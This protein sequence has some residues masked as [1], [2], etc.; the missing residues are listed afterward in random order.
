[1]QYDLMRYTIDGVSPGGIFA[2]TAEIRDKDAW[3]FFRLCFA[4][5]EE[6]EV[7]VFSERIAAA[8]SAF[9]GMGE[10]A[11]IVWTFFGSRDVA[12]M[13]AGWMLKRSYSKASSTRPTFV[14]QPSRYPNQ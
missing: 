13:Y 10:D 5:C 14:S 6:P 8:V 12:E 7:E 2:P 3:R 4:A 9:W 1:M 11:I